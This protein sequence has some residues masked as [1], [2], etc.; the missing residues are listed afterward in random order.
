MWMTDKKFTVTAANGE[1]LTE[2]ITNFARIIGLETAAPDRYSMLLILGLFVGAVNPAKV[3]HEIQALEGKGGRPSQ[4]KSPT[5]LE[6][7]P[8]KGLWHKHY[9]PGDIKSTEINIQRD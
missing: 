6:R 7:P 1:D 8:L 3:V 4:L 5:Q 9:S 2:A